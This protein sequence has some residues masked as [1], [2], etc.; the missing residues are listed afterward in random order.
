MRTKVTFLLLAMSSALI[1]NAV[2]A[3]GKTH[4]HYPAMTSGKSLASPKWYGCTSCGKVTMTSD[5]P[6]TE[7]GKCPKRAN[8]I[9]AGHAW[10]VLGEAGGTTYKC[11]YCAAS[12]S[13]KDSPSASKC[14]KSPNK[15]VIGGWGHRWQKM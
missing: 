11:N 2:L 12:V 10:E 8:V 1:V 3:V 7:E 5:F 13:T 9:G 6:A 4:T 15:N 14:P